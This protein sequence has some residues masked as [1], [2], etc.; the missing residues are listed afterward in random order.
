MTSKFGAFFAV[1]DN[2]IIFPEPGLK[3]DHESTARA[4][5]ILFIRARVVVTILHNQT[6]MCTNAVNLCKS[7]YI[8]TLNS[9]IVA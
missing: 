7:P 9:C 2:L 3:M 4:Y 5:I 1:S 8:F 6:Y